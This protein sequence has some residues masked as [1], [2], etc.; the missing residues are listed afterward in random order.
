[1]NIIVLQHNNNNK[2]IKTN[3]AYN[4]HTRLHPRPNVLTFQRW[5]HE[6]LYT[7][8]HDVICQQDANIL[9]G[10]Q[11]GTFPKSLPQTIVCCLEAWHINA[12]SCAL[13]RY[14]GSYLQ[15]EYWHLVGKWRHV[16]KYIRSR[17]FNIRPPLMKTPG[18]ECRN[19]GSCV[20]SCVATSFIKPEPVWQ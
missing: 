15:Q 16:D 11:T 18:L 13:N 6:T 14:D 4:R 7:R 5:K 2:Y 12:S 8:W 10:F 1:M 20:Q 17:V 9:L 3:A 19:V